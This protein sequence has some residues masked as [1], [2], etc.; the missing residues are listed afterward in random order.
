MQLHDG[1]INDAEGL[2]VGSVDVCQS[3]LKVNGGF[4]QTNPFFQESLFMFWLLDVEKL[5]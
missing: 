3:F 1:F 4:I 5:C 2:E